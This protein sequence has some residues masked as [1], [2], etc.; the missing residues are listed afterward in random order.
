[1][2]RSNLPDKRLFLGKQ[3]PGLEKYTIEDWLG[4]GNNAHVFRARSDE[5]SQNVACKIIPCTNLV[6]T[7]ETPPRW[8]QELKKANRV[9]SPRVVK[10]YLQA[11]D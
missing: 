7:D 4:S 5:L 8:W 3:I 1:M 2:V 10:F 11:G 9:Q 6:G